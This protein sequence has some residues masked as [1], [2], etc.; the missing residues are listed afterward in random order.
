MCRNLANNAGP[1]SIRG[2]DPNSQFIPE[3]R[4]LFQIAG[5]GFRVSENPGD[6]SLLV[7]ALRAGMTSYT[8]I[9][10]WSRNVFKA[11]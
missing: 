5:F 8:R 9:A 7:L 3:T 11:W 6:D 4:N 10:Q 1:E 2:L